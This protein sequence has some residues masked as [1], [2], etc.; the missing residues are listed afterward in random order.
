MEVGWF[1]RDIG[2][3]PK[4][5]VAQKSWGLGASATNQ[6]R[7]IGSNPRAVILWVLQKYNDRC[8]NA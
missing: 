2:V 4:C 3:V 6:G 5:L 8:E 1:G 7:P